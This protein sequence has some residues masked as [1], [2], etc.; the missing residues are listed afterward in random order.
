MAHLPASVADVASE[1]RWR[2]GPRRD[3]G[4]RARIDVWIPLQIRESAVERC[5]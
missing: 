2:Q 5:A 1:M 3:R 4:I